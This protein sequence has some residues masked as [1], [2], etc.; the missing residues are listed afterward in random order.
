MALCRESMDGGCMA[1]L[2]NGSMRPS[3]SSYQNT[4]QDKNIHSL[5]MLL[6][7]ILLSSILFTYHYVIHLALI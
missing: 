1:L 3:F 2:T 4:K 5:P 6:F 7:V